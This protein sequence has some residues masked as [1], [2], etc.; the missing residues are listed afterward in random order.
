MT[1]TARFVPASALFLLFLAS[2]CGPSGGTPG[3]VYGKVTY[4]GAPV[5]GGGIS[6]VTKEG[7]QY[8]G[9]IEPDGTY[10]AADLPTGDLTVA[11]STETLNPDK[12]SL[13]YG[14]PGQ[15]AQPNA[16]TTGAPAGAAGAHVKQGTYVKIPAKYG[17]AKTSCLTITVTTGSVKKDFDLTD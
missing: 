9:A 16:G 3:K 17:D 1:I 6:F 2:G 11:I 5:T 13:T 14:P 8:G 10:S 7:A 4:K 12:P 15:A